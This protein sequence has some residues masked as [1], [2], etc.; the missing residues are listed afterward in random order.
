ML[1]DPLKSSGRTTWGR[2]I[3]HVAPTFKTLIFHFTTVMMYCGPESLNVLESDYTRWSQ[4]EKLPCYWLA[5][6]THQ[7]HSP[8]I[9]PPKTSGCLVQWLWALSF[10]IL[11]HLSQLHKQL[12][13]QP[14]RTCKARVA[15]QEQCTRADLQRVRRLSSHP[16][17][18]PPRAASESSAAPSAAPTHCRRQATAIKSESFLE[19]SWHTDEECTR[20]SCS[21]SARNTLSCRSSC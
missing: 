8:C 1:A 6:P 3:C 9:C 4:F 17:P 10:S 2:E 12:C 5:T 15:T 13:G 19:T 20:M 11:F 18:S 16:S 21:C 7:D 14:R